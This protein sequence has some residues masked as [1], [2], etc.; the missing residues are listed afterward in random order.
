VI[1]MIKSFRFIVALAVAVF[2]LAG[3]ALAADDQPLKIVTLSTVLTEIA[4]AVAGDH[5]TVVG[6]VRPGVDPHTF[7]PSPTDIRAIVDADLVLA[8]G[9][10]LE[11]YLEQLVAH[12]GAHGRIV[13]VG[14]ALP[15][16]LAFPSGPDTSE[17]VPTRPDA[18]GKGEL[19]PHWWH[20]IDNVI[21]A[22]DV[23]RD[24]CVRLRPAQAET[25]SRSA[26]AYEQRLIALQSWVAQE[27]AT[28]P[29]ARRQLVT[30]HDAFGYFARNY[31]F[32]VHAL[33]GLSTDGET[34]A[35]HV[36]RLID[37]IKSLRIKAVFA[38]DSV[39]PKLIENLVAETHVQ[40]GGA[41]YADGFGPPDSDGA[42]YEAMYRHNVRTIVE[43]LR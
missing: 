5:A 6:V 39:N 22:T 2:A 31:G 14:D 35:K 23:V 36:A 42:N 16:V 21:F 8:S 3:R 25:F 26:Q 32:T 19:D 12:S 33:N 27:V 17:E 13:P 43:A 38:E 18:V 34:D 15:M 9:L 1:H 24:E 7:E 20:S 40:L 28:L 30:S 29:P 11:G 41:L 10:H 4:H 37:L